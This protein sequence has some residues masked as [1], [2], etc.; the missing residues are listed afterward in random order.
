MSWEYAC[1]EDPTDAMNEDDEYMFDEYIDM[2]I[3]RMRGQDQ[4]NPYIG[5]PYWIYRGKHERIPQ[6][7]KTRN[8]PNTI[9]YNRTQKNSKGDGRWVIQY[10]YVAKHTLTQSMCI[11]LR[12]TLLGYVWR[13]ACL[14]T[15]PLTRKCM[16]TTATMNTK[17]G[18]EYG[19]SNSQR[20]RFTG[21][22]V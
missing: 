19:E 14:E 8:T 21:P 16:H 7:T 10:A 6:K 1:I 5:W 12:K 9:G 3:D 2:M 17:Q 22:V 13:N 11:L 20:Y 15:G 4:A 18:E